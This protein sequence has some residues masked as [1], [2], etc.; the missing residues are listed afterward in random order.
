MADSRD[1]YCVLAFQVEEHAELTA[2]KTKAL[3]RRLQFFHIPGA[4]G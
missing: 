4:S 3:E 1:F 2:A